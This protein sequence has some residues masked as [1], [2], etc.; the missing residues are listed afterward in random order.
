MNRLRIA[1]VGSGISG[2]SSAWLLSQRHDVTLFEADSRLGGHSHTVDTAVSGKTIAIDT[3][4]IVCNSWTYPNFMALMDYLDQP[5]I[6]T[7]MSF[8]VSMN[9]HRYEYS[10]NSL[11]TL[12]GSVRQWLSPSHW[13]LIAELVRFYRRAETDAKTISADVTLG[14]YLK[15]AG[16]GES[17]IRCHILPIAG[18]IWS[19][20][21][22]QIA[23]Y[24]FKA[25]VEFFSNH[26]L[27]ALGNRPNWCT[28]AG[29]SR[30]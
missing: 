18:A 9:Q 22:D 15:H 12:M 29:G 3:G 19:S 27:F 17:F 6:E 16:Y 21:P 4:F 8:S 11:A 24:P 2:L 23:A 14:Q 26:R 7:Q 13:R 1:V 28:V 30:E 20:T 5:L 25:F 10:A